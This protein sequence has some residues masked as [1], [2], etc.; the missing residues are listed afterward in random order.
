M[1]AA[2]DNPLVFADTGEVIS[3]GNF[4]GQP[5]ALAADLLAAAATDLSSISERRIENLVNPDLSGLPGFPDAAPRP[6]LRHDARAGAGGGAGLG[7]QDAVVSRR[8]R[9]DSDLGQPRG[10]RVDEHRRR[11]EMP[12]GGR[13]M[14]RACWPASCSVRPRGWSFSGRCGRARAR[15]RPIMHMREHVRPLGRDRTLHRDLEAVERADPQ[16]QLAGGGGGC[17]R[18]LTMS[19]VYL[20]GTGRE[21][22]LQSGEP[23]D[24]LL[25]GRLPSLP[26]RE[27][28]SP[29]PHNRQS[30]PCRAPLPALPLN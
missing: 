11:P 3:G 1:N 13:P 29:A 27:S 17:V 12:G 21:F 24:I 5:I 8:R 7:E 4:H 28:D 10:P 14:R 25:D 15:R 19:V 30:L 6:E 16:R 9:F 22:D 23:A 20:R 18:C 2:T 26:A